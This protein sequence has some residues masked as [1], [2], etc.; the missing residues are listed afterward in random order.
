[1]SLIYR[2][3][4]FEWRS[5]SESIDCIQDSETW[6]RTHTLWNNYIYNHITTLRFYASHMHSDWCIWARVS[7][8]ILPLTYCKTYTI[9]N[10]LQVFD[11]SINLKIDLYHV[12]GAHSRIQATN[13]FDRITADKMVPYSFENWPWLIEQLP[14]SLETRRADRKVSQPVDREGTI[15]G[16]SWLQSVWSHRWRDRS[17]WRTSFE[18][19]RLYLRI[20]RD[21][22]V[23]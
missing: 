12:R 22:P 17:Y 16:C 23:H 6:S 4:V 15:P 14:Y 20:R 13:I 5:D 2:L 10:R 21:K 9:Y 7:A 3:R 1:M 19:W 8:K 11:C 18:N